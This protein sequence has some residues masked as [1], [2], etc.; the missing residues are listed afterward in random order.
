MEHSNDNEEITTDAEVETLDFNKPNF[1]FEPKQ[2]HEWRQQGPYLICKSCD[3][4]HAQ[5]LGMEKIMVGLN[6]DGTP[7]LKAR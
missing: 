2:H 4:D 3:I 6:E 5:Y 7:I 1:I